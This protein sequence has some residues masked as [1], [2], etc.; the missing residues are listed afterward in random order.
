MK[1]LIAHQLPKKIDRVVFCPLTPVQR[2]AY[3]RFLDSDIVQTIK[4]ASNPCDCGSGRNRGWCC[5][6]LVPG[7]EVKWQHLVFPV[8]MQLQKLSNHLALLIPS[9]Q[10]PQD[11]QQRELDFLQTM[12]PDLWEELYTNRDAITVLANPAFCGKWRVLKKLLR[13]WHSNADKVLIFSH[14]VRLLKMLAHLFRNTA[15]NVSFLSGEMK[16]EERQKTVDEFNSDPAQFVFLISTKAGGVGLNI[17]SANKVVVIDPNWN[18]S[19]D[20]QAQDRAYRI[21]QTRD[22][23]VFRLVSAGTVEECIYA[24]QIYKQQ[25]AEIGYVASEERRYFEGVQNQK[26]QKGEIF[27]LENLLSF[28]GEEVVLRGIVNKTN[29]AEAR[30]GV[31]LADL[32]VDETQRSDDPFSGL[33]KEREPSEDAALSQLVDKLV[34]DAA[35]TDSKAKTKTEHSNGDD[36][37]ASKANAVNAILAAAG[38]EY[39]H[40]NSEV[41]GS[42]RIEAQLSRRAARS[43]NL[44]AS[45]A[46]RQLFRDESYAQP[47]NTL[48]G[49]GVGDG[50]ERR[51][52]YHPPEDVMQRQFCAMSRMWGFESVREFA[53]VVEG[54]TT[55][56][57]RGALERFY[58]ARWEALQRKGGGEVERQL[59]ADGDG[60]G[61]DEQVGERESEAADEWGRRRREIEE[62]IARDVQ[63]HGN[64]HVGVEKGISS[65]ELP[66][67]VGTERPIH[68]AGHDDDEDDDEL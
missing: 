9:A 57:R 14:S 29:V 50:E 47:E 40:S 21:G 7:M 2:D 33:G 54:W 16:L 28:G 51:Y 48:A 32:D 39:T 42:S 18:P 17:T 60:K 11:K 68:D 5:H 58:A 10:D 6:A 49:S 65:A 34:A 66:T 41:I 63:Q 23:E 61:V 25:Q 38:V 27:G 37:A 62:R 31:A 43:S 45:Q 46:Q 56:Q 22:V 44:S 36:A 53:L 15:Y 24:R 55:E 1:S 4:T 35:P 67:D 20:L 12:V 26:G 13:F 8:I 3:E 30:A 52:L 59:A 19:Y 64:G